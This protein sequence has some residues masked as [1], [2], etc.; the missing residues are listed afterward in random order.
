MTGFMA[1]TLNW[2]WAL[3]GEGAINSAL[4]VKPDAHRI[5]LLGNWAFG[6]TVFFSFHIMIPWISTE[7]AR[8]EVLVNFN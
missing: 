4:E 5:H 1:Y 3:F 8:T 7:R 6:N 2:C